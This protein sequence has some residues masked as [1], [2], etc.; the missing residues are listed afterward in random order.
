MYR[1]DDP[2]QLKSGNDED[3]GSAERLTRPVLAAPIYRRY[4]VNGVW[5]G[6][7]PS[8]SVLEE[9]SALLE[10]EGERKRGRLLEEEMRG[11]SVEKESEAET[12]G[13]DTVMVDWE[14]W[15]S[16]LERSRTRVQEVDGWIGVSITDDRLE[17]NSRDARG[18]E[19]GGRKRR[20]RGGLVEIV[21][22]ERMGGGSRTGLALRP[23]LS[24]TA[25][26]A[27]QRGCSSLTANVRTLHSDVSLRSLCQVTL[28]V[29]RPGLI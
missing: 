21:S 4:S 5:R 11:V 26:A 24:S 22:R 9:S 7:L 12:E 10:G 28:K 27:L 16:G 20:V 1:R 8:D 3:D 18:G 19:S 15:V 29:L 17:A 13:D 14:G 23:G 25:A 2:Q 6:D